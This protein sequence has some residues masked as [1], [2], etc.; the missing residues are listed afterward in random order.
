MYNSSKA[1]FAI[2]SETWRLELQPLGVRT[3][4]LITLAVKTNAQKN[5]HR[6]EIPETS[7]YYKI[8]DSIYRLTDGSL[9]EGAITPRQYA[10]KVVS[11]VE[12]G[13]S[14]PVWAGTH[15]FS[16]RW[17]WW[18]S[19]QFVKVSCVF[20]ISGKYLIETVGHGHGKFYSHCQRD[21]QSCALKNKWGR[22][23]HLIFGIQIY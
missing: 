4:T 18:L 17:G 2:A 14:G 8:R 22:L 13:S 23:R 1:A 19:P 21:G 10:T 20:L 3:I 5:H 6:T 15:A 16:V 12:K 11:E 9:Q 7:Y